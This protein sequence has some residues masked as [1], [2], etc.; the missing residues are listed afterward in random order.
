M[1]FQRREGIKFA[2]IRSISRFR[3]EHRIAQDKSRP[4]GRG[5]IFGEAP[6]IKEGRLGRFIILR[7]LSVND[8]RSNIG[9]RQREKSGSGND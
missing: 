6:I 9:A 1:M 2:L 4:R 3:P 7:V 5:E 8:D